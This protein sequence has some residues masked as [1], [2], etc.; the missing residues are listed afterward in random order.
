LPPT[1]VCK[2]TDHIADQIALI[3]KI[4]AGGFAYDTPEAVYFDVT[5]FADYG[6][7]FNQSFEDKTV[8][9]RTEVESGEY[10]NTPGFCVVV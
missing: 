6:K 4:M 7:M 10:K 9:A 5:K 2:A 3:E 8:G 1:I